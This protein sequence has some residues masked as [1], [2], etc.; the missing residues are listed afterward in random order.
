MKPTPAK[1]RPVP[2]PRP[3]RPAARQPVP[4]PPPEPSTALYRSVFDSS[5]VAIFVE[6]AAGN[7]LDLNTAACAAFNYTRAELLGQNIRRLAPP[8]D[9]P[10]VAR[11]LADLLAGQVL[12]HEVWSLR[13]DGTRYPLELHEQRLTLPDGQMGILALAHDITARKQAEATLHLRDTALQAAANAIFVT[14]RAGQIVWANPAFTRTTGYTLKEALGQNPRLM[15]SGHQDAGFYRQLWDTI[16]A[17]RVWQGE[18]VNRR[19][20]GSH[21]HESAT[22]TPVRDAAGVITHFIAVKL[23]ITERDRM[24][25]ELRQSERFVRATLDALSAHIAILDE[26]GVILDVNQAWRDFARQAPQAAQKV[27]EGARYLDVCSRISNPG[28][29]LTSEVGAGIQ[30]VI[31]GET[32]VF[33]FEFACPW[34]DPPRWLVG[35][36]TRFAGSGPARLV[37]AHEDV[38]QRKQAEQALT[39][40]GHQYRVLTETMKDVVWILDAERLRFRYVSPSVQ[41]LRGYTAEE[42]MAKPATSAFVPGAAAGVISLIRARAEAFRSGQAPPEQFYVTEVEQPRKDGST[43]WTEVVTS[44][45][46]QPDT[47]HVEV[48]GVSRDIT[49]REQARRALQQAKERFQALFLASPLPIVVLD[50]AGTVQM[51]SP[52]AEIMFGWTAAEV[53]G[54]V[55]PVVPAAQREEMQQYLDRTLAGET[56]RGSEPR[57][58][59]CQDGTLADV[60]ISAAPL[61]EPDGSVSGILLLYTDLTEKTR[62]EAQLLRAQ[63]LESIGHLAGGIAHDLNNVLMPLLMA[64]PLLRPELAKSARL[65]LLNLIEASARRGADIVKQI[66]AFARGSEVDKVPVQTRHLLRETAEVIRETFPKHIVLKPN[67]PRDLWLV[68]ANSTQLH[69]VVMNLCLNAR[70]AMPDGGTLTLTAENLTVT[71]ALANQIANGRPGPHVV[72]TIRDTGHGI[73]PEDLSRIFDPFFTTKGVGQGTGLGLATVYGIVRFHHGFLQVHSTLGQG[74]EFKIFLPAVPDS[75]ALPEAEPS[76]MVCGRGELILV[77]DDDESLRQVLGA[78][79]AQHDYRVA[80]AADGH[81]ALALAQRHGA[82]LALVLTDLIMPRLNGMQLISAL[83]QADLRPGIIVMTGHVNSTALTDLA[84]LG[85]QHLLSKPC[86][87]G[88]VLTALREVLDARTPAGS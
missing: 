71:P 50:R 56:L 47:G 37:V 10:R 40:S 63:R 76:P 51:W 49:E 11:N 13:K 80:L 9:H 12:V 20:D 43:V 62:L 5:P 54:Q 41:L 88:A 68:E 2:V 46:I 35:R 57:L 69:Q 75:P 26:H 27:C 81:E 79:L 73:A 33:S 83:R 44:Y 60:L 58:S 8:E 85:V 15:K 53:L 3:K 39:L 61:H 29:G 22:I 70:D 18:L 21:Y 42:V 64:G 48:R 77:V 36:V 25:E 78:L 84:R 4:D 59:Q 7:I 55:S 86:E 23:D 16:L 34:P 14:D 24:K 19:R 74:T 1:P 45:H 87:P 28:S 32:P 38:T 67:L 6:D 17:G 30:A 66:L 31:Q 72:W 52:A 82:E 65:P